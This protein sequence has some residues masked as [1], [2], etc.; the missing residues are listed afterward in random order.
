M[1]NKMLNSQLSGVF[2]Q[3]PSISLKNFLSTNWTVVTGYVP[4]IATT[5]RFDTKFGN[6]SGENFVVIENMP[7]TIKPQILGKGRTRTV[8]TKRLQIYCVGHSSKDNKWKMERHID[9]LIN[10]NPTGLTANGIDI[11]ELGEFVEI[12]AAPDNPKNP[13]GTTVIA[14]SRAL[15]TLTYDEYQAVV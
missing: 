4:P 1:T 13:A 11:M 10:G 9:S 5:I 3:D 2:T 12:E 15:V 14:R 6:M 7:Q 8:D